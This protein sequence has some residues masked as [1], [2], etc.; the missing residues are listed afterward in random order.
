VRGGKFVAGLLCGS[1]RGSIEKMS[2]I[3]LEGTVLD[4]ELIRASST[5]F[6]LTAAVVDQIT[7]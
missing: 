2:W 7:R 4:R 6:T 3:A 1:S 5:A